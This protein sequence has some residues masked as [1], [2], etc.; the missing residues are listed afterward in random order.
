MVQ[1]KGRGDDDEPEIEVGPG[2]RCHVAVGYALRVNAS[3][4]SCRR[5]GCCAELSETQETENEDLPRN[6]I[7]GARRVSDFLLLCFP[8]RARRAFL[9][10]PSLHYGGNVASSLILC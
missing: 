10:L 7:Y 5:E 3:S 2:V 4:R 1:W 8:E 9:Y 6:V